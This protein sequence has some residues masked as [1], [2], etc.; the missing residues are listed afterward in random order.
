MIL[1]VIYILIGVVVAVYFLKYFDLAIEFKAITKEEEI[2][3]AL[4]IVFLWW[5]VLLYLLLLWIF[6]NIFKAGNDV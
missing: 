1:L 5:Y 6:N 2:K 4:L 3:L